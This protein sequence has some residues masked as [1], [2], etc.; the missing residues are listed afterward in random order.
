MIAAASSSVLM[1][2]TRSPLRVTLGGG[3]TDLPSYVMTEAVEM[4]PRP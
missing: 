1:S 4:L 2:I 3:G